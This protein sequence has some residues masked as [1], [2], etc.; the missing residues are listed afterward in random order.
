MKTTGIVFAVVCVAGVLGF[1]LLGGS[2]QRAVP[3]KDPVATQP[4]KE[5]AFRER[6]EI[7]APVRRDWGERPS[8][9]KV[10]ARSGESE[11]IP[12]QR[13]LGRSQRR[14]ERMKEF[15]TDGDGQLNDDE[16]R[17]MRKARR[18]R[19]RARMLEAF[20]ENGDGV[21]DEDEWATQ[22][23]AREDMSAERA[24]RMVL[25]ADG[26]GDGLISRSEAEGGGRRFQ[27]VL[28]RF[29]EADSDKDTFLSAGELAEAMADQ[30][31]RREEREKEGSEAP[32]DN[33]GER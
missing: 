14:A 26:D 4:V 19:R 27:R 30:R 17:A 23:L 10:R 5:A 25:D 16:H 6:P 11:S 21:L 12:P 7:A 29:E 13:R 24:T 9:G 18:D 1:L 28:R 32:P 22:N 20:D 33:D 2:D 3:S 15:D 8:L 31:A